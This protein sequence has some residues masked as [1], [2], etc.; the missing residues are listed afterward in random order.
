MARTMTPRLG[1]DTRQLLNAAVVVKKLNAK[2]GMILADG[3]ESVSPYE[4]F[5]GHHD[6]TLCWTSPKLSFNGN[7]DDHFGFASAVA[8]LS[9]ICERGAP[10][11]KRRGRFKL[12]AQSV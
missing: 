3:K 4:S 5:I 7:T 11:T 8:R 12:G 2:N 9:G 6:A 10:R 1:K